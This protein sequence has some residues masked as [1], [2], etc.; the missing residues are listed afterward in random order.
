MSSSSAEPAISVVVASVGPGVSLEPCLAA[1]ER[2]RDG[3]EV[4]VFEPDRSSPDLRTRFDWAS[5]NERPGSLVPELWREGIDAA[6]GD[7][8][9]LT[10][11]PMVPA[12]DWLETM[13][14]QLAARDVVAG[15]IDPGPRLRLSDWAEYFCRYARDLRPFEPHECLDLPGDNSAYRRELLV[16]RR[17]LFRDGFWEPVVNRAL[18]AD[19][20]ALWHDPALV[21]RQGRSAGVAAFTRQRL[22]HGRAYGSQRGAR[23]G[24]GRNVAGVLGA[25]LVPVL[26]TAR[27]VREVGSR[28]RYGL[29]LAAALPLV[30]WFNTA[31]AAGEAA[32]HLGTLRRRKAP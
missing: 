17:E 18:A 19:G 20:V 12:D 28:R 9:A 3:A 32:G 24:R 8:V 13:R 25:P 22:L 11:S 10:I 23:F 26:M 4:L 6:R 30:F 7:I 29:R 27:V 2:Q 14:R 31:W 15:A 5:F 1:I 21:V 16:A